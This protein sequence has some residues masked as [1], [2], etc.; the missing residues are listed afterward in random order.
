MSSTG[1]E[2]SPHRERQEGIRNTANCSGMESRAPLFIVEPK[3]RKTALFYSGYANGIAKITT[4]RKTGVRNED[5]IAYDGKISH[6]ELTHVPTPAATA[7]DLTS[8]SEEFLFRLWYKRP[9]RQAYCKRKS[10]DV[11]QAGRG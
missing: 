2:C 4:G 6:E 8:P 11:S 5:L 7:T 3:Q 9:R 1:I 10:P